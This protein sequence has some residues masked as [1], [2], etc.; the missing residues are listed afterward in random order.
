MRWF[1]RTFPDD[2]CY[3]IFLFEWSLI[4]F[5]TG[6]EK[7][8]QRKVIET[9]CSNTYLFDKFL[10]R[11]LLYCDKLENSAWDKKSIVEH[12]KYLR[13][14]KE[15][16]DFAEWLEDFTSSEAFQRI[17]KEFIDIEIR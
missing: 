3:P 12:F 14:D 16:T 10:D 6:K 1:A 15:M 4:L 11:D 8:T 13:T 7:E 5:K 9:Y 17:A 2:C